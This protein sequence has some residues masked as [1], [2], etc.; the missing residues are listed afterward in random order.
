MPDIYDADLN[1]FAQLSLAISHLSGDPELKQAAIKLVDTMRTDADTVGYEVDEASSKAAQDLADML[2]DM[3]T[4]QEEEDEE[5]E[6]DG[7]LE[8]FGEDEDEDDEDD[9]EYDEDDD[10]SDPE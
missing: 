8:G 1:G 6:D 4:A 9:E 5:D 2:R 3:D 10:D 7:E